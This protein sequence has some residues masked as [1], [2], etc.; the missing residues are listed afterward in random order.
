MEHGLAIIEMNEAET[1]AVFIDRETIE[2]ARQNAKT[3]KNVARQNAKHRELVRKFMANKK[4][5][6]RRKA[7]TMQTIKDLLIHGGIIGGMTYGCMVNLISPI[8]GIPVA[9]V[10]LCSAC[11]RLGAWFGRGAKK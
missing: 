10:S 3:A 8:L 1:K 7:Y 2:F 6:D 9:L 5:H 4:A 11:L